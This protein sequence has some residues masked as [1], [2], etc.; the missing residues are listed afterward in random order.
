M[1]EAFFKF[2]K[3]RISTN[4]KFGFWF[5]QA[6][7]WMFVSVV[8]FFTLTLWYGP[9]NFLHIVHIL[10]QALMGLVFS[11]LLYWAFM[12]VW[13]KSTRYRA[14]FGIVLVLAVAFVWTL[15]RVEVFYR[16]TQ[17]SEWDQFG[18]WLFASIFIFLCWTGMFHG[19][20]YF[21]LL[22]FEHDTMLRAEAE[23]REEQLMRMK[24]QSVAR[25][26]QLKMLRYQ[27]NPH[28]LCNTLNAIN[29][30]VEAEETE[31]AQ[32][33][34]VKLSKF[35]RHSLDN[36]PDTKIA[37]GNEINAL[38]LYLDIEKVRFGDRL[39]LDFQVNEKAKVA[40]V[41]SLLLQP[42][43]ENSMKHAIARSEEGGTIKI[44]ANAD[45]DWLTLEVSDTGTGGQI[46]SSKVKSATGRGVGVRNTME[47]LEALYAKLFEYDVKM[48]AAGG[49]KTR[50]KIPFEPD[51]DFQSD[52]SQP[53]KMSS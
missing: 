5:W 26:A 8:S 12:R 35:L 52:L 48:T 28:F 42:I 25:D 33:M 24:A 2:L 13:N 19:I 53:L 40:R 17:D 15:V 34:T 23:A 31:I 1:T 47:R 45:D 39:V 36:N 49:L 4:P 9:F 6:G 20:R 10:V 50:I 32:G 14:S 38:N 22:Q 37:L 18:G 16:L 30:L 41:P 43:V 46:A 51:H 7:F 21:Q 44:Y 27:L 3:H 11:L 29:A